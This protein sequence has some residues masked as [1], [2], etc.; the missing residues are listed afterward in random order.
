MFCKRSQT[1]RQK[2]SNMTES[3]DTIFEAGLEIWARLACRSYREDE[4]VR[5]ILRFRGSYRDV[6]KWSMLIMGLSSHEEGANAP[7]ASITGSPSEGFSLHW[8]GTWTTGRMVT[9]N[10][11]DPAQVHY[12]TGTGEKSKFLS[13]LFESVEAEV[14]GEII[15]RELAIKIR[16]HLA[17]G[18]GG[19]SRTPRAA[20]TDAVI[21]H[22]TNGELRFATKETAVKTVI[23]ILLLEEEHF[24]EAPYPDYKQAQEL[25]AAAWEAR[26]APFHNPPATVD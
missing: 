14:K 19:H 9:V 8:E 10:L 2:E 1:H 18:Y 3:F 21:G 17:S 20:Y 24:D 12:C 11:M 15:P 13:T 5:N 16:G 4:A 23:E 6:E 22:V 26:R 25:V 7:K